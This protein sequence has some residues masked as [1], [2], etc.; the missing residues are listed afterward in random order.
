METELE[1]ILSLQM[2]LNWEELLTPLNV[3]SS[4]LQRDPELSE[5]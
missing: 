4:A 3:E 2:I 5:G 1:D